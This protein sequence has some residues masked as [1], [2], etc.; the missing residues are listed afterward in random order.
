MPGGN[1]SLSVPCARESMP[2]LVVVRGNDVSPVKL[3][4]LMYSEGEGEH[5]GVSPP[6]ERH[7]RIGK[8]LDCKYISH[9][10][11]MCLDCRDLCFEMVSAPEFQE[12]KVG[13]ARVVGKEERAAWKW[14]AQATHLLTDDVLNLDQPILSLQFT[15]TLDMIPCCSSTSACQPHP[16]IA[17]TH[18]RRLVKD[19]SSLRHQESVAAELD[20]IMV[21]S[22]ETNAKLPNRSLDDLA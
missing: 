1:V 14:R 3:Q 9:V 15:P 8:Q 10:I 12:E 2:P 11:E 17:G 18:D 19:A 16:L 20:D 7:I 13:S 21:H 6:C 4:G 22:Q 5:G